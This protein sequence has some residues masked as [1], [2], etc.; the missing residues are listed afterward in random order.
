VFC[1]YD[2]PEKW[3]FAARKARYGAVNPPFGAEADSATRQQFVDL[4]R[5]HD[6][7]IAEVGVWNNPLSADPSIR[8]IAIERCKSCLQ[9]AEDLGARCAVNIAG[10]CGEQWD[11]PDAQNLTT[12]TFNLIVDQVREILKAVKPKRTAFALETMPWAFPDS[13]ESYVALIK[14]ID[15]TGFGVHLDIVNM[16]CSPRLYF[17][18]AR[19]SQHCVE[20]LRPWLKGV[21]LK[22]MQLRSELTVHLE[23]RIPGEGGLDLGAMLTAL[24]T[25]PTGTPVLLEHMRDESDYSKAGSYILKLA[26]DIGVPFED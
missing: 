25:L 18:N 26:A 19:F 11:G 3:A 9:L 20:T 5:R 4:C 24:G 6:L 7:V 16:I 22:D 10:S 2:D 21:H 14:A 13:P 15:D 1:S 8:S 12:D 17:D 23:E